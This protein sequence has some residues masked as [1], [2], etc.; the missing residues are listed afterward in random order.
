M[1]ALT[2]LPVDDA[3]RRLQQDSNPT[4]QPYRPSWVA[5]KELKTTYHSSDTY[6]LLY[7]HIMVIDIKILNSN[8]VFLCLVDR[9]RSEN[10][11]L[12][13]GYTLQSLVFLYHK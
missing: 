8:S 13:R 6:P 11:P 3:L 7:I 12:Q 2:F 10:T 9:P 1:L 5:V 4:L